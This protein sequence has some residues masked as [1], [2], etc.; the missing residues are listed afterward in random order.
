MASKI[1]M[2]AGQTLYDIALQVYGHIEGVAWLLEDNNLG[3]DSPVSIG[4]QL[5]LR[6]AKL[7]KNLTN[8]Y[9]SNS[10]TIASSPDKGEESKVLEGDFNEDFNNDFF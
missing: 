3:W 7:D 2:Q 5:R 8:Y 4:M 9:A 10:I 1:A 6:D